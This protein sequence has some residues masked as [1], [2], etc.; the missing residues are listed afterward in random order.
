M[1]SLGRA[2]SLL[3]VLSHPVLS[4][5][6]GEDFTDFADGYAGGPDYWQ[7]T[8]LRR[9]D[10]LNLRQGPSVEERVIDELAE[11]EV[12]RNLGCRPVS[13]QRWCRVARPDDDRDQGWV[14]GRYLR[15]SSDQP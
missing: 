5:E 7:V 6:A 13:G 8:G 9:G 2:F 10:T 15:E 14:A 4:A 12:V 1:T 11:G 3:L